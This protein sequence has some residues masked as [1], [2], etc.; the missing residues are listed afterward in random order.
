MRHRLRVPAFDGIWVVA[1]D[2]QPLLPQVAAG[3]LSI[4]PETS[5]PHEDERTTQLLAVE[6]ELNV[7]PAI[8]RA[9]SGVSRSASYA[10][11]PRR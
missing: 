8:A 5:R 7:P 4:T 11:M 2:Q 1:M 3:R 9:A 10:P 6:A